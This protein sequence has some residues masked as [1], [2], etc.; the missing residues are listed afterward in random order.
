MLN[1]GNA[2]NMRKIAVYAD[3]SFRIASYSVLRQVDHCRE[4]GRRYLYLGV[5]IAQSRYMSY[6]ARFHPHQRLIGGE[7]R[8]FA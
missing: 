8:D 7:W 1:E 4:K 3:S 5:Y 2:Q 6:K